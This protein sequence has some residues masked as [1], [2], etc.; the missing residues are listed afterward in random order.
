MGQRNGC[1]RDRIQERERDT[2]GKE[3]WMDIKQ[4][5]DNKTGFEKAGRQ[6]KNRSLEEGVHPR[7]NH[8]GNES[9]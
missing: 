1:G 8:K 4:R 5:G 9:Q 3:R 6:A 7:A 2:Q